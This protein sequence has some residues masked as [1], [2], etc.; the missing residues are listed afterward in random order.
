MHA[1]PE[2]LS[3][4]VTAGV[5]FAPAEAQPLVFKTAHLERLISRNASAVSSFGT[6]SE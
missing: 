3:V 5:E 4:Q 6:Y 2:E 1:R